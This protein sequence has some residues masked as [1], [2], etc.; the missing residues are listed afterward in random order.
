MNIQN[1]KLTLLWWVQAKW[2]KSLFKVNIFYG[3]KVIK[4]QKETIVLKIGH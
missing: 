4:E 3:R 1:Y 2:T